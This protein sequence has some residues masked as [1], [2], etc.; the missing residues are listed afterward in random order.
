MAVGVRPLRQTPAPAATTAA[1]STRSTRSGG[2]ALQLAPRGPGL[3]SPRTFQK[4]PRPLKAFR[5]VAGKGV[6]RSATSKEGTSPGACSSPVGKHRRLTGTIS[7]RDASRPP[8]A[9]LCFCRWEL[10]T[11]FSHELG[12]TSVPRERGRR[13]LSR[14]GTNRPPPG[15]C[16][17]RARSRQRPGDGQAPPRLPGPRGCCHWQSHMSPPWENAQG[18]PGT[19][20][21]SRS[22]PIAG[23]SP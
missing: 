20:R 18:P 7:E 9:L 22:K 11:H 6:A 21:T 12:V 13:E 4:R 8:G 17:R 16:D 15:A 10:Y 1:T 23:R 2:P 5:A 14:T 19:C 3:L